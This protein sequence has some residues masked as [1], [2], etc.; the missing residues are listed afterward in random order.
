MVTFDFF[1]FRV[2]DVEA[3]GS[4]TMSGATGPLGDSYIGLVSPFQVYEIPLGT[5]GKLRKCTPRDLGNVSHLTSG[6]DSS[7]MTLA[8]TGIGSPVAGGI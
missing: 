7:G 2:Q 5:E 3:L 8:K 6:E 4:S 1:S